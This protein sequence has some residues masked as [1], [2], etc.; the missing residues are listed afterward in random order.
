MGNAK[1]LGFY[2][3]RNGNVFKEGRGFA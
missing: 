3:D 2:D 1:E